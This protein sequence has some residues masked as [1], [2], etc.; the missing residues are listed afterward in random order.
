M[1]EF[2]YCVLLYG[3]ECFTGNETTLRFHTPLHPGPEWRIF[4]MS[5]FWVSYHS[6]TSRFPPFLLCWM[7]WMRRC[8]S[9]VWNYGGGKQV[10]FTKRWTSERVFRKHRQRKHKKED[11]VQFE[12][13]Q[14]ISRHLRRE[15]NKNGQFQ[16]F[17]LHI[18]KRTL[19]VGSKIW[20]LYSRGKHNIVFATRT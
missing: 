17:C 14:R 1:W 2:L 15:E 5:R 19:R 4:R 11:L 10:C 20:I 9:V 13:F 16:I 3:G 7:N 6:M 18:I 12:G 8:L